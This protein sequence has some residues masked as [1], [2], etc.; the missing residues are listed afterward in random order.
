MMLLTKSQV[1]A[2]VREVINYK[3]SNGDTAN[4]TSHVEDPQ[5]EDIVQFINRHAEQIVLKHSDR[6]DATLAPHINRI[7]HL[8]RL[9]SSLIE[10]YNYC[11]ERNLGNG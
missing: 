2:I 1:Y 9:P 7:N 6:L 4:V 10:E 11:C 8:F 5:F 3:K